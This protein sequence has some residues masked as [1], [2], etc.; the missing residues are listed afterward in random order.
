MGRPRAVW[1]PSRVKELIR[2]RESGHSWREIG[3]RL[4]LPHVTCSR[5]WSGVLG[6]PSERLSRWHNRRRRPLA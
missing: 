1:H 3:A 5:Y 2:L 6:R 4:N